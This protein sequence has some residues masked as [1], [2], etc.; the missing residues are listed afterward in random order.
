MA[1][2]TN[3]GTPIPVVVINWSGGTATIAGTVTANQGGA[4]WSTTISGNVAVTGTF[5]Q[6]TQPI[7]AAALPL[8]AGAATSAKQPALGTAGT[9]AADVLSVQ[10]VNGGA[11]FSYGSQ[12]PSGMTPVTGS[13]GNVAAATATAALP[14][15]SAKTNFV[16]GVDFTFAGATLGSV[17]IA[18]ITGLITGTI[19]Y[20]IPV[21]A[22]V[23]LAGTPLS[24]RFSPA[25]PASATNIAITFS[26]PSLGAGNTNACANIFG[27]VG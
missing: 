23:L 10:G 25:V 2:T 9:P 20:I 8:P 21:P 15:V 14:A 16:S 6:T 18:T 22:G 4:P 13:S 7:S 12:Y 24:V 27:Y 17:V 1:A 19:S 5:W 3:S 26:C 11:P